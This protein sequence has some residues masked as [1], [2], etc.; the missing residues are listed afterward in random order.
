MCQLH[1]RRHAATAI[2]FTFLFRSEAWKYIRAR[3]R[4]NATVMDKVMSVKS[5]HYMQLS[6]DLERAASLK[7]FHNCN[8]SQ[9]FLSTL[10]SGVFLRQS[11]FHTSKI[12]HN[13]QLRLDGVHLSDFLF[14]R[15]F[16]ASLFLYYFVKLL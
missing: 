16:K 12:H 5:L 4:I 14:K 8:F 15:N 13:N 3:A 1:L 6:R 11:D 7:S 2:S 9:L 10:K